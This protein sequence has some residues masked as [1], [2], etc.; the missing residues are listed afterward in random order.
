M[1]SNETY[2][3]FTAATVCYFNIKINHQEVV[4]NFYVKLNMISN[5]K[6]LFCVNSSE[7]LLVVSWLYGITFHSTVLEREVRELFVYFDGGNSAI[8]CITIKWY[9]SGWSIYR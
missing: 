4:I 8:K 6:H 5:E 1:F 2:I 9:Y 3:G 7:Y